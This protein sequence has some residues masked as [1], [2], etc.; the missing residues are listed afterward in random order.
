[1]EIFAIV[2]CYS[3]WGYKRGCLS[4]LTSVRGFF[5]TVFKP[6]WPRLPHNLSSYM[7]DSRKSPGGLVFLYILENIWNGWI[8]ENEFDGYI[9]TEEKTGKK[10]CIKPYLRRVN[11]M[12]NGKKVIISMCVI[13]MLMYISIGCSSSNKPSEEEM[14]D[15][16]IPIISSNPYILNTMKNIEFNI[17]KTTND[18][19]SK[20]NGRYC[21]QVDYNISYNFLGKHDN[22][23]NNDERYS[24][25][26]KK[27]VNGM[28]REDGVQEKINN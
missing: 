21:I 3:Q 25:E 5:K 16:I 4:G 12:I 27:V 24:F 14:K 15:I 9:H 23:K 20:K 22:I 10:G 2:P 26:K 7:E 18:F 8:S 17:F 6:R 1:M 28:V 13:L 11:T 19:F